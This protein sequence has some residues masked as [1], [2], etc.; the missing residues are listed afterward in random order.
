MVN[1]IVDNQREILLSVQGTNIWS[2]QQPQQYN[3]QSIAW[4]G[5]SHELFAVGKRYQWVAWGYVL[6]LFVPVPFWLVHR[7]FPKLRANYLYT[8]IIA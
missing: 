2:G 5:L 7:Y 6:G 1:S 3:S 4:G 8:P